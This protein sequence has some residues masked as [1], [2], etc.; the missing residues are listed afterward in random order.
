[1]C[2]YAYISSKRID[3]F[4]SCVFGTVPVLFIY[5]FIIL[6]INDAQEEE[7]EAA[8]EEAK[9]AAEAAVSRMNAMNNSRASIFEATPPPPPVPVPVPAP[10]PAASAAGATSSGAKKLSAKLNWDKLKKLTL[11]E[12]EQ[13]KQEIEASLDGHQI[14]FEKDSADLTPEGKQQLDKIAPFLLKHPNEVICIEGHTNCID[15]QPQKMRRNSIGNL[16]KSKAKEMVPCVDGG[17]RLK[18]LSQARAQMVM[19]HFST[20]GVTNKME[21]H[22]WGCQHPE[23]KNKKMVRIFP[24]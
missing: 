5:L 7:R 4:P 8:L 22:G 20:W 11:H 15:V 21:V 1:M 23:F 17:C 19:E 9:A 10:T 12:K 2:I 6:R 24:Q 18:Q 3:C 14:D 16:V 13:L